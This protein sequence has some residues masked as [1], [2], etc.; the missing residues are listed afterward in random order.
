MYFAE[1]LIDFLIHALVIKNGLGCKF[2]ILSLNTK[3]FLVISP[4][5]VNVDSTMIVLTAL[6]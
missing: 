2:S 1:I 6:T 4:V 3:L 5:I